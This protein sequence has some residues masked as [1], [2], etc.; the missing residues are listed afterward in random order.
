MQSMDK[1]GI[2]LTTDHRG[3]KQPFRWAVG[4]EGSIIPHLGIDQLEWTQHDRFWRDDLT[5][6]ARNLGC[7]WLRYSLA[8]NKIERD[9]GVFTWSW[10]DEKLELAQE[11]GL[12]LILDLVHFGVPEWL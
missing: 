12:K 10:V 2:K 4:I 9:P 8:W 11:L 3:W 6:A 7:R 1:S 5:L